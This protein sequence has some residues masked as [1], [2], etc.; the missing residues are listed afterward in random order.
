MTAE[1]YSTPLMP[2]HDKKPGVVDSSRLTEELC[3]VEVMWYNVGENAELQM[4]GHSGSML[5]YF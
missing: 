2:E 4:A 1:Y 5:T 3:C